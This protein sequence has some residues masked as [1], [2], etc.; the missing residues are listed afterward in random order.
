RVSTPVVADGEVLGEE[1]GLA[2]MED[3]YE[4]V[5][6]RLRDTGSRVAVI[7]DLPPSP[8]NVPDCVSE[9]LDNLEACTV[10]PDPAH[11]QSPDDR[12]AVAVDG[13]KLIDLTPLVCPRGLCR[14]VIGDALVFRDFDHLTP[15]FAAT[16]APMLDQRL[17]SLG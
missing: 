3:G 7:R 6:R 11:P 12:A 14:A 2:R 13:V 17:P 15:T 4:R 8:R 9:S 16:L 5:L 1:A 10:R